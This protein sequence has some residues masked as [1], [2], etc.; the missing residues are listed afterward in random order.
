[1]SKL[2]CIVGKSASG[3][4]TVFNK[5]LEDIDINITPIIPYTTRPIREGEVD[6]IHY[7]F[8][9]ERQMKEFEER[10]LVLVSTDFM[11]VCGRWFYFTVV[12]NESLK[13][14]CLTITTPEGLRQIIH[15]LGSEKVVI[16]LVEADDLI[17]LNRS[18]AR[19]A[20]EKTPNYSEVC[21]R[22]LSDEND[23][24]DIH[25]EV[26]GLLHVSIDANQDIDECKHQFKAYWESL[27]M[28]GLL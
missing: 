23:F 11:S 3:K 17:R 22:F 20:I 25:S 15:K 6:G 24:K 21:R 9:S 8:V 4:N 28:K 27:L 10:G 13:K 1:M 19:T 14:N 5:I 26:S 2:F 7:N 16:I 18:I 12:S